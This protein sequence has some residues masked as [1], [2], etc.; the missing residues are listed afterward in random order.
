MYAEAL[1]YLRCPACSDTR[2]DLHGEQQRDRDGAIREGALHCWRCRARYPIRD[3][4]VDMLRRAKLSTA[5]A[6][7]VNYLPPTAWAYERTWRPRALSLMTGE[8]FGYQRELPLIV[9][10]LAPQRGGL[11]VDIACSN[12][13]YARAI[14][15]ALGERPGHV[16]GIDHSL[17]MLREAR[18]FAQQ[19][20]LR[21]SYVRARAQQL[22]FAAEQASGLAMGGSLNEIGDQPVSLRE[23]HRVL[24]PAGRFAMM[25]L[26]R[27]EQPAGRALQWALSSGG[28]SF[29]PLERLNH[30][31]DA[32]GLR[33]VA[34]WRYRVVVF[35]LLLPRLGRYWPPDL[36]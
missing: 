13:L 33:L 18:R 32:S 10:L 17:P 36:M 4:V 14:A 21:I 16:I 29:W 27:A 31:F 15:R 19:H 26:V 28:L 34:Q 11:Y 6:Q 25:N 20:G 22:P 35:N 9:G 12:G 5:P 7:I 30:A 3:G 2:L 8:P 23:A 1:A 24:A